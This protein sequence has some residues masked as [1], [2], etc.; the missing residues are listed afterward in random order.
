MP[1]SADV[2]RTFGRVAAEYERTRPEYPAAAVERAAAGLGLAPAATV[3]DLGAGTG[4]L[5]RRLR[6]RFARVVAV[7]PDEAMRELIGGDARE[8]T[9]EAIPLP[10][11]SVDAVFCGDAFHWFDP[12]PA[13]AEIAR[14]V[15]RD[16]GLALLWNR[17]WEAEQPPI[18]R[19]LR[20][21][22]DELWERFR[23]F[24]RENRDWRAS[25]ATSRFGPIGEARLVETVCISGRDLADLTL[26]ASSP[27][28]LDDHDRRSIA[29]RVY[30]LMEADYRLAVATDVYWTTLAT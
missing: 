29:R 13:L 1:A 12:A 4:K 21:A 16:G 23:P 10:D 30:P 15:R 24:R 19:E 26:T 14:V 8:G 3:L 28:A 18:P 6:A 7:E 25:L 17:W 27:A 2:G 9:A 22:M 11:A 20:D 5:T